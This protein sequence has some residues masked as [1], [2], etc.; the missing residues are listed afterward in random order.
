MALKD[1]NAKFQVALEFSGTGAIAGSAG[2][3]GTATVPHNVRAENQLR[4]A[5][6]GVGGSNVILV[7]GR[8]AKQAAYSTL[9]TITGA[10]SGTTVDVSLVDEL[11]FDNTVHDA[12]GSPKLVASGFF[13]KASGGGGS[14]E[15]NTASNAG[16]GG[17]GVFDAK[18]GVDLQF[19]NINA[20]SSKLTVA[21]DGGNKEIDLDVDPSAIDIASLDQ[22][23]T[24]DG[25]AFVG[26][27]SSGVLETMAGWTRNTAS[28]V[29]TN[30]TFDP[31]G[32]GG[33]QF[34]NFQTRIKPSVDSAGASTLALSVNTELDGDS[35]G[36]DLGTGGTAVTL[37]NLYASHPGTSDTGNIQYISMSADIGN[38]TDPITIKGLAFSLGFAQIDANVTVDGGVQG[39]IFQP[40]LDA[41]AAFSSSGYV[42]AFGDFATISTACNGYT[43]L[44]MS[45]SIA[46]INANSGY[47]AIN[48]N[49]TITTLTGNSGATGIAISGTIGTLNTGFI[50]G[51]NYNQ[52]VS[53][54]KA[55]VVG[56]NVTMDN[57]TNYAGVQASLTI[58]DLTFEFVV[59][60]TD[61]NNYQIEYVDDVSAGS[62]SVNIS[63]YDITIHIEDGVSSATQVKTACDNTPGFVASIT[64]TISGTAGNPQSAVSFQSFTGGENPGTKKAAQFD[65]DVTIDG[66]LSFSGALSIAALSAVDSE[67]LVDGGGAVNSGHM[68]I[69]GPTAAASATIANADYLGVNTAALINIGASATITTAFLGVAALGLPAVLTMGSGATIDRVAGAIFA[70][71]LDAGSGGGTVAEMFG[72]R[73]GALPNGTTTVTRFYGY[74]VFFPFGIV[75]TTTWGFYCAPDVHNWFKGDLRVGGTAG[76]DDTADTGY[77]LHIDGDSLFEG[78]LQHDVGDVGFFGVTPAAQ[79]TGGAATAGG[80]YTAT[81]QAM[82]Q[83]AYDALRTFGFLS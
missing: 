8:I 70:I 4:V 63:G 29:N 39:Y 72:C 22:V 26:T 76:S 80:T 36:F 49:P 35:D 57:V 73:S 41:S 82:L 78:D 6:E 13:E 25:S 68:L 74:E 19:R 83:A 5:V 12:S 43:G 37:A 46:S 59:P 24:L 81:E 44:G 58:Q 15:T 16:S 71:S 34:Y 14:G 55:N 51:L 53:N 79:Q 23:G 52:T 7:K 56:V 11:Y 75:G 40:T 18:V 21:L 60:S 9:A 20:A 67:S 48:I 1:A 54:N 27:D 31:A 3:I 10:T 66:S 64:T 2:A 32:G 45:P 69:S 30:H 38:G 65:G 77:K 42:T 62:E 61:S 28:G 47:T 50:S 33:T 17:V